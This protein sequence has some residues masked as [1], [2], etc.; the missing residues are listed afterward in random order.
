[1]KEVLVLQGVFPH[2]ACRPPQL[3][4][5]DAERAE[6]RRLAA[7]AGLIEAPARLAAVS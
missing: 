7:A 5:D 4:V 6:L 2:A 1:M 3:G